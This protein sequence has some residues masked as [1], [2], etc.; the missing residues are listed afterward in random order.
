[1]KKYWTV[2]FLVVFYGLVIFLTSK[3]ASLSGPSQITLSPSIPITYT[4]DMSEMTVHSWL[5][6]SPNGKWVVE[7]IEAAPG[8]GVEHS[9][10]YH[11]LIARSVDGDKEWKLMD[12]WGSEKDRKLTAWPLGW[13]S[14]GHTF[15]Y[16][17]GE[18]PEDCGF[19][20]RKYNLET[21]YTYRIHQV[22][23][24]SGEITPE[25]FCALSQPS[26]SPNQMMIAYIT[27]QEL[28]LLE[29]SSG[30]KHTVPFQA[31][32]GTGRL[33]GHI[34]WSPDSRAFS[35]SL[36]QRDSSNNNGQ[37][38][39]VVDALSLSITPIEVSGEYLEVSNWEESGRL[40]V[41]NQQGREWVW[42]SEA[43]ALFP[44]P[45]ETPMWQPGMPTP[46]L[47]TMS[48]HRQTYTSPDGRWIAEIITADP[49]PDTEGQMTY[50]GL[51]VRSIDGRKQWTVVDS[52]SRIGL[53]MSYLQL[54]HW[55]KDGHG[56]YYTN[57]VVPDG[58]GG[59][60]NNG[61]D[62]LKVDLQN[63]TVHEIL[64][65]VTGFTW[66]A[67][68]PDEKI[69]AYTERRTKPGVVLRE[70]AT[71]R[72]HTVLVPIDPTTDHDMKII[73]SP[74]GKTIAVTVAMGACNRVED[75][76]STSTLLVN[77]ATLEVTPLLENDTRY[78]VVHHWPE[79]NRLLLKDPQGQW[80]QLDLVTRT[81]FPI[82]PPTPAASPIPACEPTATPT[83]FD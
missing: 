74:D 46:D 29:V 2:P 75:G 6:P 11:G 48:I 78:R 76:E 51:V 81:L 8:P 37:I 70:I 55:S 69:V 36:T 53:G 26:R 4:P 56:L 62:L 24:E 49:K 12:R 80:W 23:L 9:L 73:W 17:A 34:N 14:D 83:L 1:M 30:Q 44:R 39:L 67:L 71:G 82:Q 66:I 15:Y 16:V 10:R 28:V 3:A 50:T 20:P 57:R 13:S 64:P 32:P 45:T 27:E 47:S 41:H 22:D 31:G 5:Y 63:G 18:Q 60:F 7:E 42:D 40:I 54:F 35:F 77:V 19:D 79:P 58:C 52:W 68:S 59:A 21:I 25:R 72:E 33:V 65:P 38:I 61:S 43:R